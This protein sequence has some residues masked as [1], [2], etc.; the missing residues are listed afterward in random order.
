MSKSINLTALPSYRSQSTKI[1]TGVTTPNVEYSSREVSPPSLLVQQLLC[2][3]RVFLLHQSHSLGELYDKISR[4]RLCALLEIYWTQF[5]R[6]WDVLLHGNPAVDVYAGIKLAAGGEL[7]IGVGEEEWGSGEREVL[8]GLIEHTEG[9]EELVVTRFDQQDGPN[10]TLE[11]DTIPAT[12]LGTRQYA[13]PA[14]G[15]LFSGAGLLSRD[16]LRSIY[17]WTS[18]IY[19]YGE[20]A[21]GVKTSPI[22]SRKALQRKMVPGHEDDE[23]GSYVGTEE[24]SGETHELDSTVEV[25]SMPQYVPQSLVSEVEISLKEAT[26]Q[27]EV[28][29]D[30]PVKQP[31]ALEQSD[32]LMKYLTL[33]YGTLWGGSSS[34]PRQTSPSTILPSGDGDS[35]ANPLSS[36]SNI[37]NENVNLKVKDSGVNPAASVDPNGGHYLIGLKGD[38]SLKDDD[39][40]EDEQNWNTRLVLRTMY[41]D[42]LEKQAYDHSDGS[43]A[44]S[45][46]STSTDQH[47]SANMVAKR[48]RVVVYVVSLIERPSD[49][50]T[51]RLEAPSVHIRVSL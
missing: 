40:E 50:T 22:S 6:N 15:I 32:T 4:H 31:E 37:S 12:W 47:S 34:R 45:G 9:L 39:Q 19:F 17:D 35:G 7:G 48:L 26:L 38:L 36:G 33:G 46:E 51:D 29:Q 23:D 28:L 30:A 21:Y 24:A 27:A 1:G 18:S 42:M 43:S 41:V 44:K 11:S 13:G 25:P 2:A 14:D 3:H 10:M 16:S 5:A 8:E 49:Y 20:D